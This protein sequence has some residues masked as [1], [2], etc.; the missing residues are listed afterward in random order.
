MILG[1]TQGA[2]AAGASGSGG[3][4]AADAAL[5]DRRVLRNALL[6]S[7]RRVAISRRSAG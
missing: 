6:V 5:T 7:L 3:A 1:R 2:Q 4:G